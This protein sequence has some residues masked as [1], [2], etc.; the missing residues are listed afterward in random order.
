M[1]CNCFG[2]ENNYVLLL[3]CAV[4]EVWELDAKFWYWL[5]HALSLCRGNLLLLLFILRQVGQSIQF[6]CFLCCKDSVSIIY[7]L[8]IFIQS[9][10]V[11]FLKIC[12]SLIFLNYPALLIILVWRLKKSVRNTLSCSV[13]CTSI[14]TYALV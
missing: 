8:S 13:E 11:L 4:P 6:A 9:K 1:F 7:L 5:S 14:S 10:V 12:L 2:L 3:F